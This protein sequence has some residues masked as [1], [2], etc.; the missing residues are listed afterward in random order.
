MAPM[1]TDGEQ[2]KTLYEQCAREECRRR[3][4]AQS[5]D[6]WL[7]ARQIFAF[8]VHHIRGAF[9]YHPELGQGVW[10]RLIDGSIWDHQGYRS[11]DLTEAD[12]N[13][14]E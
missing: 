10:F 12:F 5:G 14:T 7:E 1:I 3:K 9:T 8:P 6:S 11:S 2:I 13:G 4:G